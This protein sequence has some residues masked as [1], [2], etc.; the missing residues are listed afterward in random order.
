M[1]KQLF[2][3]QCGARLETRRKAVP[4]KGIIVDLVEPHECGDSDNVFNLEEVESERPTN[5]GEVTNLTPQ[6]EMEKKLKIDKMFEGFD[7]VQKLNKAT[8]IEHPSEPGDLRPNSMQREELQTSSA[9]LNVLASA[10][11]DAGTVTPEREDLDE[12]DESVYSE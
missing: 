8:E 12:P 11:R 1:S 6:K 7:F 2:C 9:P 3:A 5:S 10:K 4:Q